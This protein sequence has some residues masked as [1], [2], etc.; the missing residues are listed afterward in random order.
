MVLGHMAIQP[1]PEAPAVPLVFAHSVEALFI[2]AMG[3]KIDADCR[4]RLK[5]QGLD[6]DRKLLPAYEYAMVD[7]CIDLV[8]ASAFPGKTEAEGAWLMGEAQVVGYQETFVGRAL[9]GVLRLLGPKR[10]L[11]RLTHSWRSGNNFIETR[12]TELAPTRFELW[13]N[14]VGTHPEFS[15]AVISTAMR[16][17]G[18]GQVQVEILEFVYPTCRYLVSWPE[19]S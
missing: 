3:S 6:L 5:Q 2:T 14:Q 11:H 12:V 13:V 7:R 10:I 18:H 8:T 1:V 17:A 19:K 16:L 4:A 9:F 15:Q